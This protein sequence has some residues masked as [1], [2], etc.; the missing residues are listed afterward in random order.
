[1]DNVNLLFEYNK[2]SDILPK[3][4]KGKGV[5]TCQSKLVNGHEIRKI[6]RFINSIQNRYKRVKIPIVL[7]FPQVAF[8]DK[9]TYVI[10]ECICHYLFKQ[11]YPLTFNIRMSIKDNF[12]CTEG[13]RYSPLLDIAGKKKSYS[14]NFYKKF[15]DDIYGRHF[16]RVIQGN[17]PSDS[18]KLGV[19]INDIDLFLRHIEV[20][21]EYSSELSETVTELVGN[22]LEHT[23][24][25]CLIDID[26]TNKAY[27]KEGDDNRYYGVNV[28]VLNFSEKFFGYNLENKIT[29][30]GSPLG[31]RYNKVK[32][33]Y[34]NHCKFFDEEY[35]KS[36]F[37]NIASFQDRISGKE[38]K[39]ISGGVGLTSLIKSLENK[40][41][42]HDCY[43]MSGKGIIYFEHEYLNY[44]DEDWIGFNKECDFINHRPDEKCISSSK[45]VFPGTAYN[46][47]FVMRKEDTYEN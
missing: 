20:P 11:G 2:N 22:A 15:Y 47:N 42:A 28:V 25:D 30:M 4:L 6:I 41:D 13:F 32:V 12:I 16:R 7:S 17:T 31:D 3:L 26:V 8:A 18:N 40:S 34:T 14:E 36:D 46:L 33:A 10:L 19:L 5:Y 23:K 44:N 9:L 38:K 43:M 24:T 29:S 45:V 27:S 21:D 1:M 39:V 35:N 37:Y